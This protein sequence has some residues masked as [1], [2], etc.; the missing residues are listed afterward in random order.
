MLLCAIW[1]CAKRLKYKYFSTFYFQVW[2]LKLKMDKELDALISRALREVERDPLAS[3]QL[4]GWWYAST[5]EGQ[6]GE[7]WEDG[8]P[9]GPKFYGKSARKCHQAFEGAETPQESFWTAR[10]NRTPHECDRHTSRP[11][12]TST[13]QKKIRLL[14]EPPNIIKAM[15][16]DNILLYLENNIHLTRHALTPS[17]ARTHLVCK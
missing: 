4:F 5:E 2:Q 16:N 15:I 1:L 7:M 11:V 12:S 8:G 10:K 6:R 14:W 3:L 17:S 13:K 9:F